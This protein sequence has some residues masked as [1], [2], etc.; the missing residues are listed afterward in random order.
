MR[1]TGIAYI[2]WS[3]S[4]LGCAGIHRFYLGKPFTG[5]IWLCTWGLFGIG[6]LV[7]LFVLPKMVEEKNSELRGRLEETKYSQ[8][9]SE[10]SP[11]LLQ[12]P[13]HLILK[14]LSQQP[15]ATLADC[16]LATG[17]ETSE[18]KVVLEQMQREELITVDN[19]E[20]DGAIV[21]RII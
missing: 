16:V 5:I 11:M 12:S 19:R 7:D 20:T 17:E 18:V 14:L 21:Y 8:L 15:E 1:N 2:L 13:T 3:L 9:S 6:Q 10:E 4:F